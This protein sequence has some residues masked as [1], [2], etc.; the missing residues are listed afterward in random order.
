MGPGCSGLSAPGK[1]V[2]DGHENEGSAAL[3]RRVCASRNT[4]AKVEKMQRDVNTLRD[5]AETKVVTVVGVSFVGTPS[6]AYPHSPYLSHA[7]PTLG[8]ALQVNPS[9]RGLHGHNL[10]AR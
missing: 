7:D 1:R 4:Q 3:L 2:F 5:R 6:S 8:V 10:A 9:G